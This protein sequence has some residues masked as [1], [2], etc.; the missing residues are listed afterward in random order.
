MDITQPISGVPALALPYEVLKPV[1]FGAL[2]I[3]DFK[4]L[5]GSDT[6]TSPLILEFA[7]PGKSTTDW[8]FSPDFDATNVATGYQ[9][10]VTAIDRKQ[11]AVERNSIDKIKWSEVDR[12]QDFQMVASP[13]EAPETV[14]LK[15]AYRKYAKRWPLE[16]I[17]AL[18]TGSPGI[19]GRYTIGLNGS[20]P[21]AG[22]CYFGY[23]TAGVAT[24]YVPAGGAD[25]RTTVDTIINGVG[26]NASVMS[27]QFVRDMHD[28]VVSLVGQAPLK[29]IRKFVGNNFEDRQIFPWFMS[30]YQVAQLKKDAD[31]KIQNFERGILI[32]GQ[33]NPTQSS[34]RVAQIEDFEIIRCRELDQYTTFTI[35]GRTYDWGFIMGA[36]A[37]RIMQKDGG[38]GLQI[39]TNLGMFESEKDEA[40]TNLF[41]YW[42]G[43]KC[44]AYWNKLTGALNST[45]TDNAVT[46]YAENGIIHIITARQ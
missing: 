11:Y 46:L 1:A 22:R 3:T 30:A 10:Y 15:L 4:H 12:Y 37:L 6:E 34:N 13:V 36:D 7:K 26:A 17:G 28:V 16:I 31:F 39:K 45:G 42:R 35:N 20:M 19:P 8:T 33:A 24:P 43:Y 32:P 29:P 41:S 9:P 18:T 25:F 44:P 38:D 2:N 5:F 40:V 21:V 14:L 23:T 27:V